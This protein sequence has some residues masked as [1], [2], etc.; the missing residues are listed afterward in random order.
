V[1]RLVSAVNGAIVGHSGV[2]NWN[3]VVG[4]RIPAPY[5]IVK[6]TSFAGRFGNNPSKKEDIMVPSSARLYV[7]DPPPNILPG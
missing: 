7:I 3:D 4:V 1:P 6:L 2:A 5:S